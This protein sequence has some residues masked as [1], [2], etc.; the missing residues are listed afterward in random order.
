MLLGRVAA[1]LLAGSE[2]VVNMPPMMR[3]DLGW[4]D[5]DRKH[6]ALKALQGLVWK[7][8]GRHQCSGDCPPPF[9][10]AE[11]PSSCGAPT[12]TRSP[13]THTELPK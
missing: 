5:A 1:R 4:I 10:P 7:Q 6:T 2:T 11:P 9:T 3:R 13:S 8:V 12:T